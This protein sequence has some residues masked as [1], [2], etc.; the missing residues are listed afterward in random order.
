MGWDVKQSKGNKETWGGDGFDVMI[1]TSRIAGIGGQASM[2]GARW[3]QLVMDGSGKSR[4]GAG[5]RIGEL[6]DLEGG[7]TAHYLTVYYLPST[8]R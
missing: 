5:R 4:F 2:Y 7:N 3:P 6:E 8:C 1:R